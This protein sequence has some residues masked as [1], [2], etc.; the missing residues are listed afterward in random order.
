[1]R[2][3]PQ[4]EVGVVPLKDGRAEEEY[5]TAGTQKKRCRSGNKAFH[6]SV[7]SK[8]LTVGLLCKKA[9]CDSSEK[10]R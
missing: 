6:C 10:L 3:E 2:Y 7:G 8:I 1:M 4:E 9:D 5:E